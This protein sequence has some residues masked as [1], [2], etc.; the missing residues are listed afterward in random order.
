MKEHNIINE[1]G[2]K[3][4]SKIQFLNLQNLN[5]SE[6][7]RNYLKKYIDNYISQYS[8]L[9]LKALKKLN[10]PVSE[11][12]FIDYGGGCGFLSFFAEEI[13]FKT[14]SRNPFIAYRLKKIQVKAEYEGVENNLRREDI[15]SDTSFLEEGRRIIRNKFPDLNSGDIKMLPINTRGLIKDNIEKVVID[16][17]KTGEVP[18]KMKH[19]TNTCDPYA[20]SWTEKLI[21]LKQ[22][23]TYIKSKNLIVDISNSFYSYSNNKRLNLLKYLSNQLIKVV[24]PGILFFFPSY[25]L[26][27]QK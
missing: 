3:L 15:Y 19:P 20:G 2:E 16:Y 7:N 13:G 10:K 22:L 12:T 27:I 17:I 1:A 14:V 18:S 24:G 9:F 4:Y 8:L 25:I 11:S 26:E 21:D 5:I 23:K 6:Y